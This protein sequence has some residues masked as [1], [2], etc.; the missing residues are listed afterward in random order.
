M[1]VVAVYPVTSAYHARDSTCHAHSLAFVKF[2]VPL[3]PIDPQVVAIVRCHKIPE[4]LV[5]NLDQTGLNI[6]PSGEWT[7]EREGSKSVILAGLDDKRQIT[8]TFAATLDSQFLPI[9]LLY[10]SRKDQ[11]LPP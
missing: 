4:K 10:I 7:M 9:Q 3:L 1:Q 2:E 8:A 6:V 5:I 11:P